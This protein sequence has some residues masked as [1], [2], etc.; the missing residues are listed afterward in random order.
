MCCEEDSGG[1]FDDYD[2]GYGAGSRHSQQMPMRNFRQSGVGAPGSS[3]NS[4]SA[5]G[6]PAFGSL[7]QRRI[8]MAA[9]RPPSMANTHSEPPHGI[10]Q[11]T[12]AGVNPNHTNLTNLTRPL[13]QGTHGHQAL[14]GTQSAL[15]PSHMRNASYPAASSNAIVSQQHLQ[16]PLAGPQPATSQAGAASRPASNPANAGQSGHPHAAPAYSDTSHPVGHSTSVQ[17]VSA[18]GQTQEAVHPGLGELSTR[19]GTHHIPD[20][21]PQAHVPARARAN[22][23][24]DNA[25][26]SPPANGMQPLDSPPESGMVHRPSLHQQNIGQ[27]FQLSKLSTRH[28]T[29]KR[30]DGSDKQRHMTTSPETRANA[31]PTSTFAPE[32]GGNGARPGNMHSGPANQAGTVQRYD[33]TTLGYEMSQVGPANTKEHGLRAG[34]A[35]PLQGNSKMPLHATSSSSG[36]SGSGTR[37]NIP[38]A[39]RGFTQAGNQALANVENLAGHQQ[40]AGQIAQQA[41]KRLSGQGA[42]LSPNSHVM[43]PNH[44]PSV[45]HIPAVPT[46]HAAEKPSNGS[47][48]PRALHSQF[49]TVTRS[50]TLP[51]GVG[52]RVEQHAVQGPVSNSQL[53]IT[54]YGGRGNRQPAIIHHQGPQMTESSHNPDRRQAAAGIVNTATNATHVKQDQPVGQLNA[55]RGSGVKRSRGQES[56][57]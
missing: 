16:H 46:G 48:D 36:P 26:R 15:V 34:S 22:H 2:A 41:S 27:A 39:G 14:P 49:A 47:G 17:H 9:N 24:L 42:P 51:H 33:S 40:S 13:S 43:Q 28:S 5:T 12:Q 8:S 52:P 20:G 56:G 57:V 21:H 6:R 3:R 35:E 10:R 32:I 53:P 11:G 29:D 7:E 55:L 25:I 50:A 31:V 4:M 19:N 44:Q 1:V 37:L 45:S 38:D 54:P 30:A 23:P 18:Q